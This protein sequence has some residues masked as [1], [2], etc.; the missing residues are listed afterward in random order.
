MIKKLIIEKS[1]KLQ[2][3]PPSPV[4]EAERIK[5]SLTRRGIEVIDLG[6]FNPDATLRY[7]FVPP[8]DPGEFFEDANFPLMKG[9]KQQIVKWL[10][11]RYGIRVNGQKEIFPY[12]GGK[13]IIY[14]LL[15]GLLNPGDKVALTDPCDPS[16]KIASTLVG[17]KWDTLPLLERNDY[18]PN[19]SVFFHA[20]V[21]SENPRSKFKILR[22]TGSKIA[23]P[24]A[25]PKIFLMNYPNNP[26]GA[27]ADYA[28]FREVMKWA[29]SNNVLLINDASGNEI[30]YDDY[31][32]VSLLQTKGAHKLALEQF[33][34]FHLTGI[35]FGF[36]IGDRGIISLVESVHEA[37]GY[38]ISKALVLSAMDIL[39]NYT[40]I[41]RKNNPEFN[42]RKEV[43]I[44]GLAKLGWKAKKPKAGPFVWVNIPPKYSSVGFSR[45]LLRKTGVLVTP[46]FGFGEYGEGYVRLALNLP[47]DQIQK[48][49]ERMQKHS[50]VWQRRYKPKT[51]EE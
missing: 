43:L 13:K 18:L 51:D 35:D 27:V 34:F 31:D 24:P 8:V 4:L 46:G 22:K 21:D 7:D 16:Y 14:H 48:A 39:K 47:A 3:L 17:A 19:M 11:Q 2:K 29:G 40:V 33:S 25:F 1:D 23:F 38:R 20:Q 28:F 12:F 44:E 6:E 37:L 5:H 36:L 10:E 9:L 15:L 42:R 50:H 45:M 26:T 30:C 32:P 41:V 49:L